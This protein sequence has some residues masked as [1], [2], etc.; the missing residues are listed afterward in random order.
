MGQILL[1]LAAIAS[2]LYLFRGTQ[3]DLDSSSE[4]KV[5]RLSLLSM[6]IALIG[7][8]TLTS[9]SMDSS[10]LL[11]ILNNL[12][13]YA[14]APMMASALLARA[15]QRSFTM[16]TWGRY[17]LALIAL[18]ELCRRMDAGAGYAMVLAIVLIGALGAA[19]FLSKIRSQRASFLSAALLL[20][21]AIFSWK[22]NTSDLLLYLALS[23]T[24]LFA[25]KGLKAKASQA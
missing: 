4:I 1:L 11:R 19:A 23:L 12:A 15:V 9:D 24:L 6:I 18:F 7:S 25:S 21:I 5:T 13:L 17:L 3:D 20:A 2:T 22:A 8:F 16:Q 14:G 10:T